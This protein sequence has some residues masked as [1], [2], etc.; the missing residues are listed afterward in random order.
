MIDRRRATGL[1]FSLVVVLHAAV[2]PLAHSASISAQLTTK[3]KNQLQR[4]ARMVVDLV[5]N[6]HF[7]GGTFYDIKNQEIIDRYLS[8]LDPAGEIFSPDD[9]KFIHQRFDRSLKSVYLFRGD[10][11]PAFEIF[12]LYAQLARARFAWVNRR[13]SGDFDF[14]VDETYSEPR[15]GVPPSSGLSLD[16]RWE[17]R[18]KDE[19]LHEILS[20]RTPDEARAKLREN[21]AE[22]ASTIS[23]ARVKQ[24]R[25]SRAA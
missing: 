21:Y 3:E 2:L 16:K 6:L 24:P 7:S 14:T 22:V 25:V 9:V 20:G 11:E 1:L 8:E 17:L 12:D 19:M 4:E 18:L 23:A 5:Q 10:L 13:L 15:P